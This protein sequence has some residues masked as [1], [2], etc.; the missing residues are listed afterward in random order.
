MLI[1]MEG[2]VM[3]F[4]L[5]IICVIGIAHGPVGLVVFYEDDVKDR[6]VELGYT[7]KEKIA[8]TTLITTAAL[9]VPVLVLVPA[10]VYGINGAEGFMDGFTQMTAVM[11]IMGL[12]DRLFIDEY[13][14]GHTKAWEIPGTEDLKPYIPMRTRIGKWIGTLVGFPLMAAAIA[15]VMT[16]L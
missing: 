8:R 12:F 1:L 13:W 7:T 4:I 6:V 15:A 3:C 9:F 2:V 11:L 10:M 16:L 5:L 14:V